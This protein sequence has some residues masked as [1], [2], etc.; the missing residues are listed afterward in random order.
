MASVTLFIRNIEV[1]G[2][3]PISLIISQLQ[4][5]F[6]YNEPPCFILI[7]TKYFSFLYKF[8]I[9]FQNFTK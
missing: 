8:Y 7:F 1:K 4:N 3:T 2:Y 9:I 5:G 6:L